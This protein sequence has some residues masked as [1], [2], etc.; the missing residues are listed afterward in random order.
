MKRIMLAF[1]LAIAAGVG[2]MSE[3]LCSLSVTAPQ[4]LNFF[5]QKGTIVILPYPCIEG[6]G[7]PDCMTMALQI[8]DTMYYYAELSSSDYQ[9]YKW[10]P[11]WY[12]IK[13]A[14]LLGATFTRGNYNYIK[15]WAGNNYFPEG[16][17][18]KEPIIVSG[19][20]GWA[21]WLEMSSCDEGDPCIPGVY[22][23]LTT[24]NNVYYL[25]T[26]DSLVGAQLDS[27]SNALYSINCICEQPATVTG[28]VYTYNE[29]EYIK[30]SSLSVLGDMQPKG[31]QPVSDTIPL[32]IKD[33]PGSSTVEPVDPNLIYATLMKDVLSIFERTDWEINFTL[34][35]TPSASQVP[36]TKKTIK[37][38]TFSDSISTTITESGTYTI[39]LTNPTWDYTIIGTFDY[40][41]PQAVENTVANTPAATKI[42]RDGQLILL[43]K[44]RMYNVQGQQIQ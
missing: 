30:I 24:N 44:D 27:I 13:N 1:V 12:P 36:A 26:E 21:K 41:L 10:H 34:Y 42:L 29:Y 20:I 32:F 14:S 5:K 43:Y 7:C 18:E 22:L 15:R 11:N 17:T 16:L 37:A 23:Q 39:E 35:K 3:E 4:S 6:E 25:G 8:G 28:T 38:T 33:G 19:T 2:V 31:Y 40:K 9:E